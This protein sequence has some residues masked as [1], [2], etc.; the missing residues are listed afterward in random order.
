[1]KHSRLLYIAL[2]APLLVACSD[3]NEIQP[4]TENTDKLL[5]K[6]IFEGDGSYTLEFF[7]N[8]DGTLDRLQSEGTGVDFIKQF[9]YTNGKIDRAEFLDANGTFDGSIEKYNYENGILIG[10]DDYYNTTTL[11][12]RYLYTFTDNLISS[13]R[14][15]GFGQNSFSEEIRFEYDSNNNASTKTIDYVDSGTND[16]KLTFS[17]DDKKS[18]FLHVNP[19]LLFIDDFFSFVNNVTS[20]TKTDLSTNTIIY[21]KNYTYT[22]DDEDYPTSRSDGELTLRFEYYE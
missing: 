16:E 2:L 11:D 22:Y 15:I 20:E 9:Y 1:M 10:R 6:L 17:Y 5:K 13:I 18:P 12:E 7:Y 14:Y 19:Q 21:T 8:S 4:S 3:D